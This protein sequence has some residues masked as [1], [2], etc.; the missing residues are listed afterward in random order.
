MFNYLK[1]T[2]R[3]KIALGADK[4]KEHLTQD[5]EVLLNP[6]AFYDEIIEIDLSTLEP[7]VNGPYSPDKAWKISELKEAGKKHGIEK[8]G[9]EL[10]NMMPWIAKN[11]L[12]KEAANS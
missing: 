10:R 8:V 11:K 12:V 5:K 1:A 7:Y 9:E 3:E 4:I 6:D 2:G